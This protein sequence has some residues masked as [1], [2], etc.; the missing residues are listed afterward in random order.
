MGVAERTHAAVTPRRPVFTAES[1]WIRRAARHRPRLRLV[2]LPFAG[3]GASVYQALP[4]LLPP[5][6][7]VLAVQLPG[8]EDRSRENPPGNL[9]AL[10]AACAVA[11]RPYL[12]VP[13]A[14]YGH[15]AGAL[16][17]YEV[18]HE[19]GRR[20]GVWPTHLVAGAQP[21]PHL[22]VTN[23]PLHELPDEDLLEVIRERGGLPEAV[24]RRP[25]LV[26]VLL[27]LLRSD[28]ALWENY[29][30][31]PRDPLPC[32][33]TTVRGRADLLVDASATE[34][35]AQ[36]SEAGWSELLVEGGH[37]F[38]SGL[39]R[40]DAHALADLLT[41]GTSPFTQDRPRMR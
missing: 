36:H 35:W 24:A 2:C 10:V 9:S 8:R 5:S 33:V 13:Y 40:T 32:P 3:G 15:C 27:P 11:L 1:R 18:A 23:F 41:P 25:D 31:S 19:V 12:N 34:P 6:I 22:P 28:F 30:H 37:Y 39:G 7:E 17:A 21:A 29:R 20:F 4:G 16:L 26:A 14:L 38:I